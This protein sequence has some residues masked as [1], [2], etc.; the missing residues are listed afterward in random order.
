MLEI[1]GCVFLL[2]SCFEGV[3][4]RQG[5]VTTAPLPNNGRAVAVKQGAARNQVDNYAC[6]RV[7]TFCSALHAV[8]GQEWQ[9]RAMMMDNDGW[10]GQL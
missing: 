3:C 1:I 2:Q 8:C 5:L 4:C 6:C 9:Q 7:L 10:E